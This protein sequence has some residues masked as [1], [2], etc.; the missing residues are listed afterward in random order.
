MENKTQSGFTLIELMIVIALLTLIVSIALPNFNQLVASNRLQ[1]QADQIEGL[2]QYARNQAIAGR[3]N[4]EINIDDQRWWV[5]A[6]ADVKSGTAVEKEHEMPTAIVVSRKP[7]EKITFNPNGSANGQNI[8]LC[9]AGQ[10]KSDQGYFIEIMPS[11]FIKVHARGMQNANQQMK[12]C[13]AS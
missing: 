7:A 8:V 11:G 12:T 1:A 4:Y 3:R 6:S 5:A 10:L 2:L 13:E 9:A